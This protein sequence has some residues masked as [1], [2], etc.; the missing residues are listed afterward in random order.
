MI[1]QE[2]FSQ[3]KQR[4]GNDDLYQQIQQ[5]ALMLLESY[6]VGVSL[7]T[8]KKLF[9]AMGADEAERVVY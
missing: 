8:A 2:T 1:Q 5:D 4:F 7:E 3:S 9:G 6:G